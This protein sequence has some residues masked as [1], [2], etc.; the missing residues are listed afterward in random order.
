MTR[1]AE[2][3]LVVRWAKRA[4]ATGALPDGGAG[5]RAFR[6]AGTVGRPLCLPG[7]RVGEEDGAVTEGLGVDEAHRLLVAGLVEEALPGP[8]HDRED[9]QPQLVDQV[10]LDERMPEPIARGDDDLSVQL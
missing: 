10:M 4:S 2:P 7:E 1:V 3:G 8:E 9:D 6:H 5:T